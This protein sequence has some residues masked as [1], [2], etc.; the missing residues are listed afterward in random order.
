M[1][2]RC[3]VS[4]ALAFLLCMPLLA[5]ELKYP[6]SDIQPVLKEHAHT[7]YRLY[8]QTVEINALNNVTV[9][10]T[11]AITV[12][13]EN[14]DF[15]AAFKEMYSPLFKIS[16][17]EG[18]LYDA[19]GAKV[20]SF[21]GSDVVDVSAINGYSLYDDNRIKI[22]DPEYK[23]YPFTVE[24]SWDNTLKQSLFL[25]SM[26]LD[27]ENSSYEKAELELI[28]P[29]DC[30]IKYKEYNVPAGTLKT[31]V[32]DKK[33]VYNW[34]MSNIP[35][36][37]YEPMSDYTKPKY[38]VVKLSSIDFHVDN[39]KG[40]T[41]S[42]MD[43]GIWATKL[44][45]NRDHLSQETIDKLKD[46]TA[47][48]KTDYEKAKTVYEYMQKKTRYV[49]ISMGIGG[50]QTLPATDVEKYSYGDCK[51]LSNFSKSLLAAVGIKSIY[52]L[53]KAGEN[54]PAIDSSFP[55]SQ[56]NHIIVC[57]PLGKDTIWLEN[58]NQ[59]MPFGFN[60]SFT[61][62]RDVLL[63]DGE[64]SRLVHTR[65]YPAS[66]NCINRKA[67]V[68]LNDD[69]TAD[70]DVV[71][72]YIGL[73]YEDIFNVYYL[74]DV[75][76]KK[77]ITQDISIPSFTLNNFQ[78]VDH[79]DYTPSMDEILNLT[80]NNYIPKLSGNMDL[81]SLNLMNKQTSLPDKVRNRK[82]DM[83]I[84]RD[85][86]EN[87]TITYIIPAGYQIMD[88]PAKLQLDN[89]FGSYSASVT[90]S[91]QSVTYYRHFEVKK[92]HFPPEEY[93]SFRDFIELISTYDEMKLG[94]KRN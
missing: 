81:L 32:R 44:N 30:E 2:L 41:K 55:S 94:L 46:L 31:F 57:L 90:K 5:K 50:W 45:E 29:A 35:A 4:V 39:S 68:H 42:W 27:L 58:T 12:L 9:H 23:M 3:K 66:E 93:S 6:V 21:G 71:E 82:S 88:L 52:T 85:Y 36:R 56:F 24:Y 73:A 70:A 15:N 64:N 72:K 43:I 86:M 49:N 19:S 8:R 1:N 76:K 78:L 62:D 63:V 80:L 16:G 7:V 18:K 74:D 92:G 89:K 59:R 22:I 61:D 67:T 34:S 47:N 40:T 54:A 69:N 11:V 65:V 84:R 83:A 79:R 10:T 26:E 33:N 51:A 37:I 75:N 53:V 48:C 60:G 25:P 13:N 91:G 38:P 14:G 20:K 17:I 28:A 77:Q 87:D